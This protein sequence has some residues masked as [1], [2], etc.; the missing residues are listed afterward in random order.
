MGRGDTLGFVRTG[1]PPASWAAERPSL[2]PSGPLTAKWRCLTVV[3][4][5]ECRDRR[6]GGAHLLLLRRSRPVALWPG[7]VVGSEQY[8]NDRAPARSIVVEAD[9]GAADRAGPAALGNAALGPGPVKTY[10]SGGRQREY[11]CAGAEAQPPQD[12]PE[13]R[14]QT[15]ALPTRSLTRS[16]PHETKDVVVGVFQALQVGLYLARGPGL[17]NSSVWVRWADFAEPLSF[18]VCG[19]SGS[20][21]CNRHYRSKAPRNSAPPSTWMAASGSRYAAS[22]DKG[23]SVNRAPAASTPSFPSAFLVADTGLAGSSSLRTR[24]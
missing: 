8:P 11:G 9:A 20:I 13:S 7:A 21:W 15:D 23:A 2:T 22:S 14:F 24:G 16:G 19:G 4:G 1:L 5:S 6:R 18:G 3:E 12:L 17:K 10:A